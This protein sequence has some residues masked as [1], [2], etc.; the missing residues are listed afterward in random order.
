[1][2]NKQA[3]NFQ[4]LLSVFDYCVAYFALFAPIFGANKESLESVLILIVK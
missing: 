1:M 2:L 4:S 3:K